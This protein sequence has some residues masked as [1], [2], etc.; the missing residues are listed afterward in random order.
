MSTSKKIRVRA[1]RQLLGKAKPRK[2]K[3]LHLTGALRKLRDEKNKKKRI[4]MRSDIGDVLEQLTELV[5]ETAISH[6][7]T[8]A[9]IWRQLGYRFQK[10]HS[11]R[12]PTAWAGF[13]SK[14]YKKRKEG[15]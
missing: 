6:G 15:Q 9:F 11:S 5:K 12:T 2:N 4:A 10:N 7:R 3:Y 8:E 1:H 14:Q 13:I